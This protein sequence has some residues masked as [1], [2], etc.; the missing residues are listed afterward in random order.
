[1]TWFA[2]LDMDGTILKLRT[3]DVLVKNLQIEDRLVEID[4]KYKHL[5]EFEKA[6]KI[7]EFFKG[8]KPQKLLNI[9]RK[10]PLSEGIEEIIEFFKQKKFL[11]AI[12][13]NSYTY[14]A[15]DLADRL[16]IEHVF[17]NELE[18]KDGILT[19]K[20]TMPLNWADEDC[21]CHSICKITVVKDFAEENGISKSRVLAIG[22]SVNDYCMLRYAKIAV[23]YRNKSKKIR[24]IPNIIVSDDFKEVLSIIRTRIEEDSIKS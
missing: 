15:Q 8:Y 6:E 21:I 12:V 1:M 9:F 23:A 22:D 24:S 19:G 7:A 2:A 16:G 20:V 4:T 14:L 3:I 11:I 10:V 17:G 5:K 13:T 18:V